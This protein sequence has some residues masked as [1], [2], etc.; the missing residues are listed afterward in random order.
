MEAD[1]R[2]DLSVLQGHYLRDV[3]DQPGALER[4]MEA[5]VVSAALEKLIGR[6]HRKEFSRIVLTGMGASFY[7]LHP[8]NIDL[9]Q[10]GYTAMMVETSELVHYQNSLF[11]SQNLIIAVSQSGRSAE[12]VRLLETNER[13]AAVLAV[14]N[15]ADSLL[16]RQADAVI[17]TSAGEEFSVSCKT[18]VSALLALNWCGDLLTNRDREIS[19]KEME[20]AWSAA[21]SYLDSWQEHVWELSQVLLGMRQLFFVGRGP[22]LAAVGTGALIVKESGRF[23]AEGMSSAAFRHGPFEM[24]NSE[25]LVVVFSGDSATT[26]LNQRLVQEIREHQGVAELASENVSSA[27]FCLPAAPHSIRPILEILPIQMIT[28]ALAV[29]A[30]REPGRFALASKVTTTE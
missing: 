22:S 4:T 1:L 6:V 9:I 11:D 7:A 13:R 19:R 17:L 8:L 25:T 21:R 29:L 28:L 15:H 16:A 3:L 2:P 30:E 10:H 23:P 12:M 24:L 5:L 20:S 18:Y 26:D 27:A 14:T